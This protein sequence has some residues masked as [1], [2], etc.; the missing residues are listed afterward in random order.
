MYP[1]ELLSTSLQAAHSSALGLSVGDKISV[2]YFGRDP[3]SGQVRLS[4]RALQ[5]SSGRVVDLVDV[6]SSPTPITRQKQTFNGSSDND[7]KF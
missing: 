7:G 3:V 4:R 1:Y 2:K 6:S 5:E